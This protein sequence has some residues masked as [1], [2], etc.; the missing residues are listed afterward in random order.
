V[1]SM[2]LLITL[3]KWVGPG[4]GFSQRDMVKRRRGGRSRRGE[5][6]DSVT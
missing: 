2:A 3:E 4:E 1:S 6:P 5:V